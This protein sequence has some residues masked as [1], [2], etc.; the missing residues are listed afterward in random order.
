MSAVLTPVAI[1]PPTADVIGWLEE[2]YPEGDAN[3]VHADECDQRCAGDECLG[4][5]D[6]VIV[7]DSASWEE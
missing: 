6:V 3:V 4:G 7:S 5:C 2:Q 1:T